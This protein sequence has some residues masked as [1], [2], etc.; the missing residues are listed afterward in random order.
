VANAH[1][2]LQPVIEVVTFTTRGANVRQRVGEVSEE[3]DAYAFSDRP[4]RFMPWLVLA[5]GGCSGSLGTTTG[6][7]LMS[8]YLKT[9]R[10]ADV[11]AAVQFM[12]AS[13]RPEA[14]IIDWVQRLSGNKDESEIKRW[15]AVF[16]EHPEFFH[17]YTNREAEGRPKAALRVRYANRLYDEVEDK[18]YTVGERQ[19]LPPH[20]RNRLTTKPLSGEMIGSM[21]NTAIALHARASE[22]RAATR[23]WVP[24]AAAI[25]GFVGALIGGFVAAQK[26][27]QPA[28]ISP[29]PPAVT[30]PAK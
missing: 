22:D 21:A 25:L 14:E 17:V 6:E 8:S 15:T 23:W 26:A 5:N 10:L 19:A 12:G 24:L 9:G 1:E 27:E 18:T 2:H 7:L 30:A 3:D 28:K 11:I 16:N 4:R 13:G 20:I 29:V